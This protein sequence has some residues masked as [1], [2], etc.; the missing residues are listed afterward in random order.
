MA[1]PNIQAVAPKLTG[2]LPGAKNKKTI[3]LEERLEAE[4]LKDNRYFKLLDFIFGGM[5]DGT[6]KKSEAVKAFSIFSTFLVRTLSERNTQEI[7]ERITT[8]EEAEQEIADVL[9]TITQLRA[10]K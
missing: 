5:D 6:L 7:I 1:N 4:L 2:R 9:N 8:R 10:V 3:M